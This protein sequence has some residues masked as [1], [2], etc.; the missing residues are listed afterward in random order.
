MIK[1]LNYIL[2]RR[3]KKFFI[4]LIVFSIFVSLI[5]VVGISA[6]MPFLSIAIDFNYIHT[7]EYLSKFYSLL[8]FKSDVDFI[9]IFGIFLFL[10]Y[11]LRSG[12]NIYYTYLMAK[13]SQ[14]RFHLIVYRLFENYMGMAYKDFVKKNSSNLTKSIVSEATNLSS[15]LSAL[16]LLISELFIILFIYIMMLYVNYQVTL[17]LT[18]FLFINGFLVLKTISNRIKKHGINRSE[19][20]QNFYEVINKSFGNF[21]LIKLQT[22]D[23]LVLNE[24]SHSSHSFA[25]TNIIAQTLIQVPKFLLEAIAFGLIILLVLYMIWIYQSNISELIGILSMFI[26]ALYRLMPSVNRIISSYNNILFSYKSLEIIHNDLMYDNE[27]LG[28]DNVSFN[29]E[30]NIININ[31]EYEKN[32]PI[33]YNL[34]LKIEKNSK[35]AFVGES[36]GGKST[37]V[38]II[39]GLYKPIA[40][41]IVIDGVELS[42]T[43]IRDW[44]TKIGYIPQT[45]YLFDGTVSQNVVFG[46]KYD[47]NKIIRCLKQAKIYEFLSNKDGLNTIVGEGGIMLSGGQKQR[48]AMAR[49]LYTDP[50]ILVLDEATSALDN[51]TEAEIMDEI[52]DI[53]R[54]K[55]LIIIAHRLSTVEKC[56]YIYKLKNGQIIYE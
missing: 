43:N 22:N 54:G 13:F 44:R 10:F 24:F 45:V 1:K 3:D 20:L 29:K 5:E 36:G 40:G 27:I 46:N 39:I 23:K 32:K 50:E 14:G 31:F 41:K 16:L 11:I 9:L 42:D 55:T 35:I 52:Y 51:E 47:E 30:I 26:L 33:L 49:A 25:K 53:S 4:V 8:D 21:K 28:K 48:I 19:I 18:L 38:D 7:N 15:L 12:L 2:T 34:N 37:L 6:I 17:V 56:D